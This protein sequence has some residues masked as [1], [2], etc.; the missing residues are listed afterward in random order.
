MLQTEEENEGMRHAKPN[1]IGQVVA[2]MLQPL[3]TRADQGR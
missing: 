2:M 1:G 3:R